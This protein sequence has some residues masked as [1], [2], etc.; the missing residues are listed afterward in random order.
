MIATGY[1]I[2]PDCGHQFPRRGSQHEP[3]ASIAGVLSGQKTDTI[4]P[5]IEVS[6][7]VHQK[8]DAP[9]DAPCSMRVE[10]QIGFRHW[11]SEWICFEHT[12]YARA[13]AEAWWK[14]HSNAP[15]PQTAAEAVDL[16]TAGAL[17][18]TKGITIR[19][20]AGQKYDRIINYDLGEKLPQEVDEG[21]VLAEPE[22][23]Y[24]P[25]DDDCPF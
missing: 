24:V 2:C 25:A 8:H 9:P 22:P 3:K 13:K 23:D 15:V 14:Q 18:K 6:Y 21:A 5:V 12:G 16:A 1:T 4:C 7:S 10:Y 11:Q 19:S 17:C 20:V